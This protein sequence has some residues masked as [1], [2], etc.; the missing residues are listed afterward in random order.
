MP[1]MPLDDF[2]TFRK[3]IVTIHL[4]QHLLPLAENPP[5]FP[6]VGPLFYGHFRKLSVPGR[7]V[8]FS[9]M[10]RYPDLSTESR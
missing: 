9:A 1:E 6:D 2:V 3:Q 4:P 10:R 5:E 8:S 7:R